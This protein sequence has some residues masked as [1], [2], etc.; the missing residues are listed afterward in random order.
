M[1][2]RNTLLMTL[3]RVATLGVYFED[4]SRFDA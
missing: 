4:G 2:R 3:V 1:M